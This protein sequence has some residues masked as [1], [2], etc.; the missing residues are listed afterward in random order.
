MEPTDEC[1]EQYDVVNITYPHGVQV[2]SILDTP[3]EPELDVLA[4]TLEDPEYEQ[5]DD[6]LLESSQSLGTQ[7]IQ[8]MEKLI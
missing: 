3:D 4:E 5:L 7:D 1:K 8:N 6:I 2:G